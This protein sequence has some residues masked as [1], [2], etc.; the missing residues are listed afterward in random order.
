MSYIQE[1]YIELP[2]G[3][4]GDLLT[5]YDA[6]N[7]GEVDVSDDGF[8]LSDGSVL[9]TNGVPLYGASE[10]ELV[11]LMEDYI[12]SDSSEPIYDYSYFAVDPPKSNGSLLKLAAV[13]LLV[14]YIVK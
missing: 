13:G 5:F 14:Y 10:D 6:I 4:Q 2:D 8:V 12:I 11:I 7:S 9:A 3:S 1:I